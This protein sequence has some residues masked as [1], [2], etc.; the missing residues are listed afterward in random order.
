MNKIY[1]IRPPIIFIV[2][3]AVLLFM[4]M[5]FGR[6]YVKLFA[7]V[8]KA[9]VE[10]L[11]PEFKVY[12][13][14][15]ETYRGQDMI[16]MQVKTAEVIP[17][18][19]KQLPIG[20][21]IIPKTH[22]VNLYMH[23]VIIFA[24]LLAWPGVMLRGR[25]WMLGFA[26]PLLFLL[27]LID[28]PLVLVGNCQHLINSLYP[29]PTMAPVRP[30]VYW[31]DFLMNGGRAVFSILFACLAAA[32]YYL[33]KVFRMVEPDRNAPCLCG[34]GKKYKQCCMPQ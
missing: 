17:L 5:E 3:Y 29:D 33:L 30:L 28:I 21:P 20:Y 13:I 10:C 4:F 31:R 23:P 6:F 27:E 22:V 15:Y 1:I 11:F 26:V 24:I 7:P 19:T 16:F 14:D 34:S 32:A 12:D 9:E 25:L 18:A 8:F 2:S